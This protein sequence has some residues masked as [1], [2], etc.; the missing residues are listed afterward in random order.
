MFSAQTK[1]F[2]ATRST[3][4]TVTSAT[5]SVATALAVPLRDSNVTFAV[6]REVT[7][8]ARSCH[9]LLRGSSLKPGSSG[10]GAHPSAPNSWLATPEKPKA[11]VFVLT[12]APELGLYAQKW[13]VACHNST[14]TTHGPRS[15]SSN[16][17][18]PAVLEVDMTYGKY[19]HQKD[20]GH[21]QKRD[22]VFARCARAV[23]EQGL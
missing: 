5:A 2:E 10:I 18:L 19:P 20:A 12:V 4:R 15:P 22:A 9:L 21:H 11:D 17:A 23:S 8:N 1:P 16:I 13:S 6:S 3:I 14:D 7:D